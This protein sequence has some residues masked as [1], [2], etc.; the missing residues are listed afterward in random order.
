[1]LEIKGNYQVQEQR[2][3]YLCPCGERA[4]EV[5]EQPSEESELQVFHGYIT[6]VTMPRGLHVSL[7]AKK[8]KKRKYPRTPWISICIKNMP[9]DVVQC[10]T[11]GTNSQ[12]YRP[13]LISDSPPRSC[14]RQRGGL[15]EAQSTA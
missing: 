14:T 7:L 12:R 5:R 8:K 10:V 11:E 15:R 2:S 3:R 4:S 13:L 1:M 9:I 6:K